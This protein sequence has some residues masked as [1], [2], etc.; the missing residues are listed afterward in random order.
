MPSLPVGPGR[1]S[2]QVDRSKKVTSLTAPRMAE[3]PSSRGY[4]R[5]RVKGARRGKSATVPGVIASWAIERMEACPLH[6]T[7][8]CE[9]TI[10]KEQLMP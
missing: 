6:V 7:S 3:V 4:W 1:V 2:A 8:S 5:A 10:A 9:Y